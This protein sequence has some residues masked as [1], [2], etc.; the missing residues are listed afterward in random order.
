M[1]PIISLILIASLCA[2]VVPAVA[3]SQQPLPAE[4]AGAGPA[5]DVAVEVRLSPGALQR[6]HQHVPGLSS[7][8][9]PSASTPVGRQ[10]DGAYRAVVERLFR[11]A[12]PGERA[13]HLQVDLVRAD[14]GFDDDGWF[15]F[16]EHSLIL[17]ASDGTE[18]ARW[19]VRGEAAIEGVGQ[20]AVPR[21]FDRAAMEAARKFD[22]GLEGDPGVARW[23][24]GLGAQVQ[25]VVRQ[26]P[27]PRRLAVAP[28]APGPPRSAYTVYVDGG[29]AFTSMDLTWSRLS[30]SPRPWLEKVELGSSP[31]T[32]GAVRLGL[33][34]PWAIVQ[35]GYSAWLHS[36]EARGYSASVT[37]VGVD[38]GLCFR[39]GDF[40]VTAGAG[41][42]AVTGEV[43]SPGSSGYPPQASA[44]RELPSAFAAVG[45]SF[46]VNAKGLRLRVGVEVRSPFN[47]T[48]R[49]P[50]VEISSSSDSMVVR[51]ATSVSVFVGLEFPTRNH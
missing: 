5:Y 7:P 46:P 13:A 9:Q 8:P 19:V 33:S 21:A 29:L 1:R 26:P 24:G 47:A 20:G 32:V 11:K 51:L 16:V 25:V 41:W 42:H 31:G 14:T 44:T 22:E 18:V 2:A 3:R 15:A 17:V 35:F 43:R 6:D 27:K 49:V 36:A 12:A 34:A 40:W 38:L 45:H 28:P 23:L 10:A 39:R 37:T 50:L 48:L 30:G 4:R